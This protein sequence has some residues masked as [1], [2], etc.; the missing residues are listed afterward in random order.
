MCIYVSV[1][2]RKNT[3]CLVKDVLIVKKMVS[4][5]KDNTEEVV[6]KIKK[7]RHSIGSEW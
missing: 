3:K 2:L 6:G 7:W 5:A 1:V 4:K